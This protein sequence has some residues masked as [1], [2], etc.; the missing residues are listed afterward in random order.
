[1]FNVNNVMNA[2]NFGQ[3]VLASVSVIVISI[4]LLLGIII[5]LCLVSGLGYLKAVTGNNTGNPQRCRNLS[6]CR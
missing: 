6:F 3:S 1:M 5:R 2:V 4:I